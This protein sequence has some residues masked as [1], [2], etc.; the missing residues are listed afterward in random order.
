MDKVVLGTHI[1][2]PR[3]RIGDVE[4]VK[5]LLT[6]RSMYDENSNGEVC[7]YREVGVWFGIPRYHA[8]VASILKRASKVHDI[9][10]TGFAVDIPIKAKPRPDQEPVWKQYEDAIQG[11]KHG[12]LLRARTGYGKTV[13]LLKAISLIGRPTLVIVPREFI[14]HQW[15]ERI[16]QHTTLTRN[17]IGI[18]QQGLCQFRG[19]KIV[20]GMIH[21]L[22]KDKYP[23]VFKDYF[24][25]V[26]WDEVHLVGAKSFSETTNIFP[27]LYRL[28][29]SATIDRKDGLSCIYYDAIGEYMIDVAKPH[30][31]KPIVFR[32]QYRGSAQLLPSYFNRVHK[33][34]NRRG[35]IISAIARDHVRTEI[36]TRL[37]P[38]VL[39]KGRRVLIL[40]ERRAQL[41]DLYNILRSKKVPEAQLGIFIQTTPQKRRVEIVK[42]CRVILATYQIFAMAVDLPPDFS[43]FIMATPVS[44][45]E[46][47]VGRIMREMKDKAKPIVLDLIDTD[48]RD[49]LPWGS[50]RYR[51]WEQMDS[52]IY[53]VDTKLSVVEELRGR[54]G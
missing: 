44:D 28:G 53:L 22:C 33:K 25:C 37:V 24:G 18:A 15:I 12:I 5:A 14:M 27:A 48:Y 30:T 2:I 17:E 10:T 50:N 26:V 52:N 8:S 31:D 29:A 45:V 47:G 36:L 42:K 19:K 43:V 34:L 20:V 3:T 4:R 35:I 49:A 32:M 6:K 54:R 46:Q 39:A 38:K 23:K 51:L 21:S 1:F 9:R 7:Q 41:T 40:S 16:L 11:G 13:T